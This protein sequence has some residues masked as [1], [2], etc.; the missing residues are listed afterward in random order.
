MDITTGTPVRIYWNLHKHC[1]SVQ[2]QQRST[3]GNNRWIVA[4]HTEAISLT[5]CT[6][7]V[8]KAG[9]ARV[10]TENRKN[11]HAFIHGTWA[12]HNEPTA[13]KITY[14]PYTMDGFQTKQ[15]EPVHTAAHLTGITN[16]QHRPS[17][18]I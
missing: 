9:Q 3:K 17:I 8:S 6:F 16:D 4:S 15:G 1:Y 10:R 11:V 18:T 12:A 2:T 7:N 5:D 13:T 14:D